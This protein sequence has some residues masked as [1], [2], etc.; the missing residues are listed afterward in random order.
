MK[1]KYC[2]A[3]LEEGMT[4][5]P[6]CGKEQEET[7]AAEV[8]EETSVP[9][10]VAEEAPEAAAP[11]IKEGIKSVVGIAASIKLVPPKS[12]QRSE[13]KAKRT[14]DKRGLTN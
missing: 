8:A 10:T 13:G 11:E 12:I 6:A 7:P 1:C 2:Q 3:E 9:E 5:C 14:I 4:V